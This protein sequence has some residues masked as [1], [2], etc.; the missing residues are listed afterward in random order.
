MEL[1][2]DLHWLAEYDHFLADTLLMPLKG[3]PL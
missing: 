2:S 3:D 1:A